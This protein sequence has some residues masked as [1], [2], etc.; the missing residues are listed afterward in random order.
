MHFDPSRDAA[1]IY[2]AH[3]AW[4]SQYTNPQAVEWDRV[5]NRRLRIGYVSPSLHDH[6]VGRSM[7]PLLEQYDRERFE[8]VCYSDSAGADHISRRLRAGATEW[9]DTH[10]LT[11]GKL[12]ELIRRHR[13][14]IL[15]DLTL[16]MN[17]NRLLVFAQKPAP[18]QATFIGYPATTGLRQI[19]YR[20]TD[21]FLDPPGHTESFN[22]ETLVRLP[23]SFWCYVPDVDVA[24]MERGDAPIAFGS[25]NNPC[26]LNDEVIDT[27]CEILRAVP[28]SRLML[29][30]IERNI[31][32]Q[33]FRRLFEARGIDSGRL[34]FVPLQPRVDYLNQYNRIDICLDPW[35]YN[36][37]MTSC[38][39]LWM[40]VPVVSL[41]AETSVG[42]GGESLLANLDLRELLAKSKDGYVKIAV[43][44][45]KDANRRREFHRTLRQRKRSS[46]LSDEK[47]FARDVYKCFNQMWRTFTSQA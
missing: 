35:P 40:G 16:H 39:A 11:D 17:R 7:L 46:P 15:V 9:H 24:I 27:W 38:D 4:A 25:L 30:V 45:A 33:R 36:G 21:R 32:G 47:T 1:S 12:T 42:R 44:L 2:E 13:I 26:K 43:D 6:P 20:I 19:D 22:S 14:D 3:R 37:H 8:I 29:F 23:H 10:A 31:I 18:I 28:H 41:R 5:S 34:E